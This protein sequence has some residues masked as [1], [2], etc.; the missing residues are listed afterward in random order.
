MYF[1]HFQRINLK[2]REVKYLTQRLPVNT[3][4][5]YITIQLLLSL[6]LAASTI[7]P[8]HLWLMAPKGKARHGPPADCRFGRK[9]RTPS[10]SACVVHAEPQEQA[11]PRDPPMSNMGHSSRG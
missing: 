3:G 8:S 5:A 9:G 6:L 10:P 1:P 7:S 4:R 11:L 2:L